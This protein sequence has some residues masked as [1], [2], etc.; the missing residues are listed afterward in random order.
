MKLL[1]TVSNETEETHLVPVTQMN[2]INIENC[3]TNS[4]LH[5]LLHAF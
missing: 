5:R 4:E 3:M 1:T 2:E